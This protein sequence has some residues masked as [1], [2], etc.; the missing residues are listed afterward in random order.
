VRAA[1]EAPRWPAPPGLFS[2][3]VETPGRQPVCQRM[4]GR[5]FT[6]HFQITPQALVFERFFVSGAAFNIAAKCLISLNFS[7]L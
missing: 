5:F 4:C 1:I 6:H 7:S 2:G 3:R